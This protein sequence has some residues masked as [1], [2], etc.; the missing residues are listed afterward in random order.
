MRKGYP[1]VVSQR[2]LP[3]KPKLIFWGLN[4]PRIITPHLY[5]NSFITMRKA[6]AVLLAAFL[7]PVM[8][9]KQLVFIAGPRRSDSSGVYH[10]FSKFATGG[11]E[12]NGLDGW[13]WPP[14][15]AELPGDKYQYFENFFWNMHN[16]TIQSI[17]M[18]S[19]QLA[20]EKAEHGI[21]IGSDGF[22]NTRGSPD[23]IGLKT[24]HKITHAL[25]VSPEQVQVVLLYKSPRMSQWVSLF[26]NNALK[27]YGSFVCSEA[28]SEHLANIPMNPF[29]L[30]KIYRGEGWN[31]TVVDTV[32]TYMNGHDVA[33]SLGCRVLSNTECSNELVFNLNKEV[34]KLEAIDLTKFDGLTPYQ[35]NELEG[36]FQGRDCYYQKMLEED[37]GFSVLHRMT[38]WEEC[39]TIEAQREHYKDLTNDEY[40][41]NLVQEQKGCRDDPAKFLQKGEQRQRG[42]SILFAILFAVIFCLYHIIARIKRRQTHYVK[43]PKGQDVWI[44]FGD[45]HEGFQGPNLKETGSGDDSFDDVDL[46]SPHNKRGVTTDGK[47]NHVTESMAAAAREGR[48]VRG[49]YR[50]GLYQDSWSGKTHLEKGDDLE[51]EIKSL[52]REFA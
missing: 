49:R 29:R 16:T 45:A 31:V 43:S 5:G 6:S 51:F 15:Q 23:S 32:G 19:I 2:S 28:Y 41:Y 1:P 50:V 36:L 40:F 30:A 7:A 46:A 22:A 17:L 8:G 18:G 3:C 27:D 47:D 10:F 26:H 37:K 42:L 11:E 44:D 9:V 38:V 33:H 25:D 39:S 24:M 4:N 35:Q 14:P 52:E 48:S 34:T 20:W 13:I 12:R 21:I